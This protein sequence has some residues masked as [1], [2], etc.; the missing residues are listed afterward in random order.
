MRRQPIKRSTAT[1][2]QKRP[3][4]GERRPPRGPITQSRLLPGSRPRPR[5]RRPA[6][7]SSSASDYATRS[8]WAKRCSLNSMPSARTTTCQ[9]KLNSK[10]VSAAHTHNLAM[11]KANKL[12]H[13]L[14]GEAA[15]GS[16]VS[17]AGYH[18]SAVGETSPTTPASQ[19]GVLAVKA[20]YNES[21][22]AATAATFEQIRRCRHRRD[23]DSVHGSG[24]SGLRQT[25][26]RALGS[27]F[28]LT[29]RCTSAIPNKINTPPAAASARDAAQAARKQGP[30][31]DHLGQRNERCQ[32]AAEP[33]H[34]GNAARVREYRADQDQQ[35][36][37]EPPADGS[38]R[39]NRDAVCA[40]SGRMPTAEA[41]VRSPHRCQ[42]RLSST[43]A[44]GL[45]HRVP[46]PR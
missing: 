21:A 9:L 2:T 43:A 11:A 36:C 29:G 34:R 44:G 12:S 26:A 1:A 30:P 23:R 46:C 41:A 22:H 19:S 17:A 3:P 25:L 45:V 37:W 14:S 20:M 24:W 13:Q 16:R 40:A 4:S 33:A 7:A 28:D 6:S 8:D 15:L 10:L 5:N 32:G 18:W 27:A 35:Q 38:V 39:Q 42:S 31:R